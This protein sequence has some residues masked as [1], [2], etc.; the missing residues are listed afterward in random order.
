VFYRISKK[1]WFRLEW[2]RTRQELKKKPWFE[3]LTRRATAPRTHQGPLSPDLTPS[4]SGKVTSPHR[5]SL[6]TTLGL[7]AWVTTKGVTT[8]PLNNGALTLGW[9]SPTDEQSRD[10]V[11]PPVVRPPATSRAHSLVRV[12]RGREIENDARVCG[13][14]ITPDF[15]YSEKRS[16]PPIWV[17]RLAM[18]WAGLGPGGRR[19]RWPWHSLH[20]SSLRAGL[21]GP[22]LVFQA[23]IV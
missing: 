9:G 22:S 18:H 1:K 8:G 10:G 13:W 15:C 19:E 21:T 16:W 14:A 23:K 3:T 11:V 7:C 2:I 6:A 5:R 4:E 12:D 17:G 20:F